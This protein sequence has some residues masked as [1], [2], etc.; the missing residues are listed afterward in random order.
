MFDNMLKK[1]ILLKD[2]EK[3]MGIIHIDPEANFN[4]KTTRPF[5]RCQ[6]REIVGIGQINYPLLD[7]FIIASLNDYYSHIMEVTDQAQA[8]IRASQYKELYQLWYKVNVAKTNKDVDINNYYDD[9]I[10]KL[11][12]LGYQ[13]K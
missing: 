3:L 4:I 5:I 12:L 9:L 2:N 11:Y 7:R 8:S 1:E 10:Y 13:Q 6:R